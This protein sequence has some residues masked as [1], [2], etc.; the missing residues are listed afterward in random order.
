MNPSQPPRLSVYAKTKV[1]AERVVLANPKHSVLR[2][3][4]NFGTSPTGDRAFNEQMR[5]RRATRRNA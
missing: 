5:R 3:S 2:T 1:E 4:L